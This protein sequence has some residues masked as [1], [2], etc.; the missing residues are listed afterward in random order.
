MLCGRFA[1]LKMKSGEMVE[2]GVVGSEV[3]K[4]TRAGSDGS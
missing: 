4:S 3:L 1:H 2:G